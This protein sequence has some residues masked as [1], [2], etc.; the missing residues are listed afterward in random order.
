[1]PS[2]APRSRAIDHAFPSGQR[3]RARID[4]SGLDSLR[5]VR[6]GGDDRETEREGAPRALQSCLVPSFA[7]LGLAP[8]H[9]RRRSPPRVLF[10]Q[11][12]I[13]TLCFATRELL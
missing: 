11:L 7:H 12:H 8:T 1:V 4:V 6:R 13:T 5:A 2:A 3:V 10:Q 9:V